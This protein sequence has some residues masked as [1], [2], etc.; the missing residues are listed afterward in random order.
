MNKRGTVWGDLYNT[1][2][3]ISSSFQDLQNL[4]NPYFDVL[5][6]LDSAIINGLNDTSL[7]FFLEQGWI[8]DDMY[9][10]LLAFRSEIEK[11]DNILWNHNDFDN[12]EDW[13][14]LRNWSKALLKKF[15]I[16]KDGWNSD[17]EIVIF[18]ED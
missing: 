8:E 11:L 16:K 12:H 1:L 9:R 3:V 5:D 13:I 15:K 4:Q 18:T 14:F 6:E 2:F 7:I 10:E 17:G